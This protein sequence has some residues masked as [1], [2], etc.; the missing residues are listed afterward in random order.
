MKEIIA[1]VSGGFAEIEQKLRKME[2]RK[3][4]EGKERAAYYES[5][6]RGSLR[7]ITYRD[8]RMGEIQLAAYNGE[9]G[10]FD[11]ISTRV[12]DAGNAKRVISRLFGL[13]REFTLEKRS[14]FF[15]KKEIEL[16]HIDQKGNFVVV[17]GEAGPEELHGM[18]YSLG[19]ESEKIME[20]DLGE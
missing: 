1:R 20:K 17:K 8:G 16:V 5:Q 13:V 14:Y 4:F 11:V 7:V 10:C 15:E 9:N 12:E 19:I 2:A 3:E 6:G 18:I